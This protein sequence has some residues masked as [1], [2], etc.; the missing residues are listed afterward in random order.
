MFI[1]FGYQVHYFSSTKVHANSIFKLQ[2]VQKFYKSK[3]KYHKE[4]RYYRR[5]VALGFQMSKSSK[6][7]SHAPWFAQMSSSQ[8][9]S[10]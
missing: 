7:K 3:K 5:F 1:N 6:P 4:Q 9:P 10:I 8:S 2:V